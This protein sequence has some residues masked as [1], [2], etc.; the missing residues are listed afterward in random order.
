MQVDKQPF[1]VNT[2]DLKCKEVLV[3]P[4]VT[5]KDKGK[6]VLIGDP[7]VPNESKETI[8]RK[9]VAEKHQTRETLNITIRSSNAGDRRRKRVGSRLLF[10]ASQM[11]WPRGV[12]GPASQGGR[13]RFN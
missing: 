1:P 8:S 9:V 10:C 12:D 4:V 11:V 7:W 5:D 3:R 2:L 6:G 13:S